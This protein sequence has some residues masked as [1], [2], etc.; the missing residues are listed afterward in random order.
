M[1]QDPSRRKVLGTLAS[2]SAAF[3]LASVIPA[4]AAQ[5]VT[6]SGVSGAGALIP[7]PASTRPGR[8]TS[9]R[10]S[11]DT[12]IV[13]GPE[14]KPVADYLAAFLASATGWQPAVVGPAAVSARPA[15]AFETDSGL[16][17][18]A[19]RLSVTG[20][21]VKISSA[22]NEGA[23]RALA[24][25][26]QL[27]P[28]QIESSKLVAGQWTI[29]PVEISD[30]P[31]FGYRALMLDPARRFIPIVDIKR[32]IDQMTL[33]K[34]NVLHLHLTDDQGW[35]LAID[36]YPELT[37]TGAST[38]SGFAPGTVD[39]VAGKGPWFYSKQEY[40]DLVGYAARRFIEIVPEVDGPGH[41]SAALASVPAIN[42]DGKA[43]PPYSGFDVGISLVGLQD[44][45]RREQVKTFLTSVLNEVAAQTPGRYLHIGGDESPKATAEQYTAYT[46]IAND[47]ATAA[48]KKVLAWHEW[49]KGAPLPDGAVMQYWGTAPGSADAALA[50]QVVDAGHQLVLSPANCSYLDMKYDAKTAYGR[51]WAGMINLRAAWNWEP[52]RVLGGAAIAESAVLGVEAS[53][54]SD[55][56]N[57]FKDQ[58][59]GPG[60]IYAPAR[61]YTDFMLFPRLPAIAELG[62][63]AKTDRS[64]A[65]SYNALVA[66]ILEHSK[67]WDA[68]GIGYNKASDIPWSSR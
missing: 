11:S 28:A 14:T 3:L 37:K 67:R 13:A 60:R 59:F 44:Q 27:L 50:R 25:L 31:R 41:T 66:R 32:V 5:A 46:A 40:A 54:W 10:L 58:P 51:S 6:A 4:T 8:G 57:Q 42:A 22:G 12:E 23:F 55:S 68:M 39:P 61:T 16:A 2:G 53:L 17:A 64:S 21:G 38:Q 56:A 26:R 15:L 48:G 63:S 29:A 65:A 9:F 33:Y 7:A 19:Y 1:A 20:S 45:Q 47:V 24:T 34:L 52:T 18:E 30:A 62:W 43:I 36:A 49:A 35:R